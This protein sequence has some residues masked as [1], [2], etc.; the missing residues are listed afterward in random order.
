LIDEPD[1]SKTGKTITTEALRP[2]RRSWGKTTSRRDSGHHSASWSAD[3]LVCAV[4]RY[5]SWKT[6]GDDH[7]RDTETTEKILKK[8]FSVISVSL[9]FDWFW[10][11]YAALRSFVVLRFAAA[12]QSL[13]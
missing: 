12:T 1:S 11:C 2:Q 8:P 6:G 5:L 7:H 13:W 10:L 4:P 3:I 9:W